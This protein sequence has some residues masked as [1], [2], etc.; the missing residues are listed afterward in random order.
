MSLARVFIANRGEIAVRIVAACRA[1]GLECV[2][3]ASEADLDGLAARQADRVVCIGP[4]PAA[5]SYLRAETIVAAALGTGCDAI[6]P[7][8]G[9]LSESPR[10]AAAAREHGLVFVG[11]PVEAIELAGDKLAARA[12]AAAA[13]LPIVEGRELDDAAD[14]RRFARE[15]GQPLMLKAAAGGGGRGIKL[16]NEASELQDAYSL[17][18]AEA[19]AAF[20][21]G[22]LYAE[23]F[24]AAARHV[25]VQVAADDQGEVVHL[26]E[27]DCS[28]QR[29]YQKLIEEAP[30]PS[31]SPETREALRSGAIALARSIGYR[32]LG[33]VEFVLDAASGEFF[34]LEVNCRIQ[35]EHPVTEAVTGRDLVREQLAI[36]GGAPLSF[37]QEEVGFE[38]HA[39]EARLTAEDVTN[40]FMP[41]PGRL[42]RF[43]APELE[44]LRVD[45]HCHDGAV[46]A[47]YYDSLMAKLIAHGA[48]REAATA[49]LIEAL[50]ALEVEGVHTNRTL[51]L[52]VLSHRDFAHAQVTTRWLE[53]EA[54][55]A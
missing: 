30:A 53:Q 43:A 7:G 14:A 42:T 20:G 23:R 51:L 24:V 12:A 28:V 15:H 54:I 3:G 17:A 36:A 10:L 6:H 39:I 32:N 9:F 11:P 22:R 25:E 4:P 37:S 40:S 34:F 26:G 46:I 49:V 16:V 2:V 1:A 47:P 31:L 48:D 52:E 50:E 8:Y 18:S 35:V 44:G 19:Q 38:G 27:R 55:A 33:T 45:T 29:R 21:D 5:E 13:G 41:S